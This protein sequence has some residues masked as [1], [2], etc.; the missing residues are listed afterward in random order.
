MW[1]VL[2][3]TLLFSV[4]WSGDHRD[5]RVLT[6]SVPTRRSSDLMWFRRDR[7]SP[8]QARWIS[9]ASTD[10]G[11]GA[12][13][14]PPAGQG[15]RM[16]NLTISQAREHLFTRDQLSVIGWR[17]S[18]L[19]RALSA[20]EQR[21]VR[22]TRYIDGGVWAGLRSADPRVGQERVRPVRSRGS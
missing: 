15:R 3:L 13:R 16:R 12:S 8:P 9:A 5:L 22:R 21:R 18:E 14:S 10:S 1:L 7:A 19:R 11:E 2:V 17:E 6:H 4:Y 20:G